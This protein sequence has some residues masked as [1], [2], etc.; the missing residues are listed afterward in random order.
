MARPV[1]RSDRISSSGHGRQKVRIEHSEFIASI[2]VSRRRTFTNLRRIS[3]ACTYIHPPPPL[4]GL[5]R[6]GHSRLSVSGNTI[7][8]QRFYSNLS[9]SLSLSPNFYI[10]TIYTC[11]NAIYIYTPTYSSSFAPFIFYFSQ[12]SLSHIDS[13]R[14]NI[15]IYSIYKQRTHKQKTIY[16]RTLYRANRPV[17]GLLREN[18]KDKCTP[19]PRWRPDGEEAQLTCGVS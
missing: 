11:I 18:S 6:R 13:H 15:Y 2:D 12:H 9:L 1:T 7:F 4:A 8:L 14:I 5:N 19:N 16:I 17:I 3:T 10:H